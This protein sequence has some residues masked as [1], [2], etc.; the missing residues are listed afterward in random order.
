MIA[1]TV[2][3][4]PLIIEK[5]THLFGK[6]GNRFYNQTLVEQKPCNSHES[7]TPIPGCL[8]PVCP[9]GDDEYSVRNSHASPS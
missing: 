5:L 2:S 7:E 9:D 6:D 4:T 1:I 3:S 8:T